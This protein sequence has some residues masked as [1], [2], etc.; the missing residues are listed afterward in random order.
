MVKRGDKI[1]HYLFNYFTYFLVT[2]L[3][4]TSYFVQPLAQGEEPNL[5]ISTPNSFGNVTKLHL[6]KT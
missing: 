2:V 6:R 4:I 1:K 3:V 5:E